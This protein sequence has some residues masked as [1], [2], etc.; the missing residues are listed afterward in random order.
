MLMSKNVNNDVSKD[1][2]IRSLLVAKKI[3]M[4]MQTIFKPHS[5]IFM[6]V[7]GGLKDLKRIHN[8]FVN[9]R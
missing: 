4:F 7:E 8:N 5:K 2:P 6:Y 9:S 3:E 1:S